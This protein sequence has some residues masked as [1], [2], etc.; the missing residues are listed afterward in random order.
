MSATAGMSPAQRSAQTPAE[1]HARARERVRHPQLNAFTGEYP[2]EL[3]Q[4]QL[5]ACAALEEGYGVLVCAPTGAGKTV[6]G[7]FAVRL[8]LAAGQKC[9]Y[10]TPIKALSNQKHND[11]VARYGPE[12]IGLLPG[13]QSING[14]AAVAVLT[15]DVPRHMR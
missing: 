4:F 1:S 6:V 12:R 5:E 9:F 11:L 3:D 15:T 13:D 8:A 14:D 2:F 10:T 7:E